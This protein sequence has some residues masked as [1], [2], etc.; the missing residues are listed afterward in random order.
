MT[1]IFRFVAKSRFSM[2]SKVGIYKI[3]GNKTEKNYG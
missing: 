1:A 3:I 2:V